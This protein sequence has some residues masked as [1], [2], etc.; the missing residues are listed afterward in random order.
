MTST[1]ALGTMLWPL[2]FLFYHKEVLQKRYLSQHSF[3]FSH[4]VRSWLQQTQENSSESLMILRNTKKTMDAQV[5]SEEPNRLSEELLKCLISIFLKM[6]QISEK[7]ET[8]I[9]TVTKNTLSCINPRG[10]TPKTTFNCKARSSFN[11]DKVP[12]IDPYGIISDSDGM[13]TDIGPYKKFIGITRHSL[14]AS[15]FSDSNLVTRKL[16]YTLPPSDSR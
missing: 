6:N 3:A 7:E 12:N 13:L 14:R 10:F 4:A 15:H 2:L 1:L 11:T 5:D 9:N 16:R 8:T